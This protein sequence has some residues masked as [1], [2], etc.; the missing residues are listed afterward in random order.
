MTRASASRWMVNWATCPITA[1]ATITMAMGSRF[2]VKAMRM[3]R[4]LRFRATSGRRGASSVLALAAKMLL[5]PRLRTMSGERKKVAKPENIFANNCR[6]L[7]GFL[8]FH[9][10]SRYQLGARAK[11]RPIEKR[12]EEDLTKNRTLLTMR[13]I[14]EQ[15]EERGLRMK[16]MLGG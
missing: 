1:V 16:T 7:V 15:P 11:L 8:C 14:N 13:I 4:G 12:R 5:L 10:R 9:V 6:F 2:M 3:L